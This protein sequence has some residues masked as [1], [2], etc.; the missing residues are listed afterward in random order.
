MLL[1]K[2]IRS[3]HKRSYIIYIG[4][5]NEFKLAN[6]VDTVDCFVAVACPNN[7]ECY[8]PTKDDNYLKPVVSPFEVLAALAP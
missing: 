2:F 5:L 8:F 3:C 1:H 6:F 7:R 4:H